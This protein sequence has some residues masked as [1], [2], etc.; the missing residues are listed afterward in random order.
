MDA[1]AQVR[2]FNRTMTHQIGALQD[3]FLGRNRSLG[4]SRLLFEIGPDGAEVSQLRARLNLD[5][6]YTSRLLR[7]LEAEGLV[8]TA[9]SSGDARVRCVAL[10][11][12]GRRELAGLNSR[13][14][15]GAAALLDRLLE[16]QRAALVA[17]MGT[18][19]RLL[20]ASGVQ[21]RVENPK[22]RGARYCVRR[23]FEELAARFEAGFD[24]ALTIPAAAADLTPP[25]GFFVLATLHGE[26]VGC[27]GLK[28]HAAYGEIKRMWVSPSAR[29]L[30]IGKRILHRLEDLARKRP[31]PLLRLETNRA[32]TEAQALYK[33]NGYREV[34]PFN[35]EPYAHHWF[36]KTL[37]PR[38]RRPSSGRQ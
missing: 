26:P 3:H 6:G 17:A 11:T 34:S 36:Q 21:L 1:I 8:R 19:E 38:K 12:A 27:G 5:S 9:A 30:G 16:P 31:L 29:G 32:L 7:G 20:L 18:V 24:P 2:S 33:S 10:T 37:E 22:S 23:Y 35:D 15:E 28:C 14:D 4:A 25:R 13:S